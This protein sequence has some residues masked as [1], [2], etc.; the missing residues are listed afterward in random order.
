M[1]A[2]TPVLKNEEGSAIVIALLALA[3]LT[4]LGI[5][6][7]GTTTTELNIVRN[8]GIYN[9]NFYQAESCANE[10]AYYIETEANTLNLIPDYSPFAWVNDGDINLTVTEGWV[11]TGNGANSAAS[12]GAGME[13]A[14]YA[15]I[16]KGPRKRSSLDVGS[17]RLYEFSVYGR[18]ESHGGSSIVEIG[19]LRRF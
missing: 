7:T 18:S 1:K 11:D 15:L 3:L 8:L 10:A 5:S 4:V 9:I 16:A 19:Y 13:N 2:F 6:S 14:W 17:S 12:R